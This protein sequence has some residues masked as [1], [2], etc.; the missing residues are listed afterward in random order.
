MDN[1]Q[2]QKNLLAFIWHFLKPY[3][4]AIIVYVCLAMLAECEGPFTSR[5]I[6]HMINSIYSSQIEN[7]S[8]LSLPAV[9]LVLN[10]IVFDNFTR[11]LNGY[12]NYKFQPVIKNQIISEI[13]NFILGS[14]HHFFHDNLAGR[15]SSQVHTLTDN[16]ERILHC[17]SAE[18]IRG[19]S[20]LIIAFVSTYYV[21][22]K[23]FY[24]LDL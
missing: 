20:L 1:L 7:L 16:I 17:I 19:I 11:R 8:T 22:H 18:F 3:K 14:S 15:I 24:T 4:S 10:F 12:L 13:F 2:Y 9:L 6:K 23:F 21:N 5:L